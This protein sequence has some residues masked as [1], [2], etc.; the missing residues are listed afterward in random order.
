VSTSR[1]VL[2]LSLAAAAMAATVAV[3]RV[4]Y[5]AA[6][7]DDGELRLAWRWRSE[8]LDVCRTLTAQELAKVPVHMRR[9]EACERRLR[10]WSLEVSVDGRALFRDSLSATGAESDRPLS[11]F[12]KLPLAPGRYAVRVAFAPLGSPSDTTRGP[13]LHALV[14]D[15]TITVAPRQ[16][17]LVTMDDERGVLLLKTRE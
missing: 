3:S 7:G 2:G 6:P 16:V 1:R 15:T 4:P 12:R 8:R 13:A 11:V 14:L 17:V 9:K 5:T 10:P